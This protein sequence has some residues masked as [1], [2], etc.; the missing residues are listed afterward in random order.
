MQD[1][2]PPGFLPMLFFDIFSCTFVGWNSP[3]DRVIPQ[4]S[5]THPPLRLRP[6]QI[7]FIIA[8]LLVVVGG[9][10]CSIHDDDDD[11]VSFYIRKD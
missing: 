11:G 1:L 6:V 9:H 4:P 5:S 8:L 3:V 7:G 10:S 2:I